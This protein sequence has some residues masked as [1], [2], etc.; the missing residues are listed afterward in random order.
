MTERHP[1][2]AAFVA[3][4]DGS[5]DARELAELERHVIGC[6]SC[7]VR[8]QQHAWVETAMFEAAAQMHPPRPRRR[9][10]AQRLHQLTRMPAGL[11][12][13]ASLVLGLGVP[14]RWLQLDQLDQLG[15]GSVGARV[16]LA[17]V[18]GGDSTPWDEAP[19]CDVPEDTGGE[20]CDDPTVGGLGDGG[21]LLAMSLPEPGDEYGDDLC[22]VDAD[23][24]DLACRGA[25]LQSG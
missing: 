2:E 16:A 1:D 23:G 20:T 4:V 25:E 19:A 9:G 12:L 10:W 17:D 14:E 6:A 11:G 21:D 22:V 18:D 13:A 7:A 8:L 24:S 15:M 3:Y 5:G